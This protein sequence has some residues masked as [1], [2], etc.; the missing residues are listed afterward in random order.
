LN[1]DYTYITLFGFL[2]FEPMVI[3]TNVILFLLSLVYY[4]KLKSF[5]NLYAMQMGTFMLLMG[6]GSLFGAL[7]HAVHYQLGAFFFNTVFFITNAFSLLSIYYCFRAAYTYAHPSNN[8]PVKYI[9]FVV[10]WIIVLL[11]ISL[12][13]GNF[14]LI[15]IHAGL[16]LIYSLIVHVI[17]FGRYRE[18]GSRLIVTGIIVSFFSIVIH[19]LRFSFH[20]WFNYKDIAHVIMIVSLMII[21]KGAK[22]NAIR[23]NEAAL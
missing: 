2:V 12:A 20:E 9:Y 22:L 17:S 18:P 6:V 3:V 8:P 1:F 5:G 7:A 21:Y 4:N 13:K 15:K 10:L 23:L 14:L 16:V 11:L 19:S